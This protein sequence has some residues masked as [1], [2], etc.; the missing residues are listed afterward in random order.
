MITKEIKKKLQTKK[1][2]TIQILKKIKLKQE[3]KKR[4]EIH[5]M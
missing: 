5:S 2:K 4:K 1:L 3:G